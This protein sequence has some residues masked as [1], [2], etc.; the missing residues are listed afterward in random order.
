LQSAAGGGDVDAGARS[1]PR[2]HA[3][4]L[5]SLVKLY[6]SVATSG[7]LPQAGRCFDVTPVVSAVRGACAAAGQEW[8]NI[9]ADATRFLATLLRFIA[10]EERTVWLVGRGRFAPSDSRPVTPAFLAVFALPYS[11]PFCGPVMCEPL[12]DILL[13]PT[14][15]SNEPTLSELLTCVRGANGSEVSMSVYWCGTHT[16]R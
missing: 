2:Q 6:Q 12:P 14:A 3:P 5:S 7:G 10:E 11:I 8:S 4:V 15:C 9:Q 13:F 16:L 1:A